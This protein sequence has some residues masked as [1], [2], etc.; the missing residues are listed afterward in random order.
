M[1]F[2]YFSYYGRK[3]ISYK[4]GRSIKRN[5]LLEIYPTEEYAKVLGK[6]LQIK[7]NIS[8][9]RGWGLWEITSP[10]KLTCATWV[11]ANE[12]KA[13]PKGRHFIHGAI[14]R[15]C[16][17]QKNNLSLRKMEKNLDMSQ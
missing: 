11:K 15:L 9:S 8:N 3:Y 7:F 2:L 1:I 14:S 10:F 13:G 5:C 17:M 4:R 12:K 16:E 6:S